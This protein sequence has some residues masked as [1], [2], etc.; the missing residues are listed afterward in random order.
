M[1]RGGRRTDSD[2]SASAPGSS[3]G[4]PP[5]RAQ[6]RAAL[7]RWPAFLSAPAGDTP[8]RG[9]EPRSA[10]LSLSV[11]VAPFL[12]DHPPSRHAVTEDGRLGGGVTEEHRCRASQVLQPV[13]GTE[14]PRGWTAAPH[15]F[16]VSCPLPQGCPACDPP[17]ED[18]S[19]PRV[20]STAVSADPPWSCL[21]RP[22]RGPKAGVALT[23]G[24]QYCPFPSR[25][26]L[27]RAWQIPVPLGPV[28]DGQR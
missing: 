27:N 21:S 12:S 13:G 26:G 3:P 1:G 18:V 11:G 14:A 17:R 6:S 24:S 22:V 28:A 7:S 8:A 4:R 19:G 20:P 23:P 25:E 16:T 5:S 2:Q 9:L 10:E 15:S